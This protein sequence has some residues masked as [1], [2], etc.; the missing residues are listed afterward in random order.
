MGIQQF[1]NQPAGMVGELTCIVTGMIE[2]RGTMHAC[3]TKGYMQEAA[4]TDPEG[5]AGKEGGGLPRRR[6]SRTTKKAKT[7][8]EEYITEPDPEGESPA[9]S[10]CRSHALAWLLSWTHSAAVRI[11]LYLYMRVQNALLAGLPCLD[12]EP[13]I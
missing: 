3:I 11:L 8:A 10:P 5:E 7:Y 6:S 1:N 13:L 12:Y 4:D 2:V 9:A